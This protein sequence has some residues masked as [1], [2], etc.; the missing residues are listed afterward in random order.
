MIKEIEKRILSSLILIPIA[1]FFIFKGSV[2]FIFFLV[3]SFFVTSYEWQKMSKKMNLMR[4]V[5]IIFL[6][7]SF[8]LA[9][10]LR[11]EKGFKFFCAEQLLSRVFL[12]RSIF[13]ALLFWSYETLGFHASRRSDYL[14]GSS[15]RKRERD[16]ENNFFQLFVEFEFSRQ[17]TLSLYTCKTKRQHH[18]LTTTT[19]QRKET[20][21]KSWQK[22]HQTHHNTSFSSSS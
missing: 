17:I 6:L 16:R 22:T 1:F 15:E 2:F 19:S 18:Q 10:L 11:T 13:C 3:I 5:G 8:Y 4:I 12:S 14:I 21:P 20:N 7:L 9:Y